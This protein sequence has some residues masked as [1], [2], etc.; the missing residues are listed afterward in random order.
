VLKRLIGISDGSTQLLSYFGE[1]ASFCQL[2]DSNISCDCSRYKG[3][4]HS[5][6]QKLSED[7]YL[8]FKDSSERV[9]CLTEK[10]LHP[11]MVKWDEL[12]SFLFRSVLVPIVVSFVTTVLTLML[13]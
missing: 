3:E 4:L 1:G 5:I 6:L 13:E 12:K 8:V 9:F 11:Y 7:G 10:G 2:C